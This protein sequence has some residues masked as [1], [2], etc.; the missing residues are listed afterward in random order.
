MNLTGIF[1]VDAV[2]SGSRIA[3]P[4]KQVR[5]FWLYAVLTVIDL[6]AIVSGFLVAGIFREFTPLG[7]GGWL[8]AA[9]IAPVYLGVAINSDAYGYQALVNWRRGL[10]ASLPALAFASGLVLFIAFFTRTSIEFSRV[11]Y[12]AG[13]FASGVAL[14]G[15][16]YVFQRWVRR[17]L[18][19]NLRSELV[20]V[21]RCAITPI[22]GVRVLDA[23]TCGL[24]PDP[25]DPMMLDRLGNA[26]RGADYVL[27]CCRLEDRAAWA[28]LLKGTDVP[29]YVLAPEYDMVGATALG[30]FHGHCVMQVASGPLDLRSRG[31][32][33]LMDLLIVVPAIVFMTP[34]L[35]I[36]AL[37][38]K[39]DSPGPVFFRQQ[40]LGRNNRLFD[41][42]KFR[43]MRADESD[44]S[45]ARSASRDDDRIT[46]VGRFIRA[47]SID[48]L[49]QFINVL[50]GDM[51]V[52]GPR[53]HALGSLA[54]I[55]RFWDVDQRY[56]HRHALKPGITGLAQIRGFRGAT[57]ERDDLV[58]RLQADLEYLSEWSIWKDVTI[59][60]ATLRVVVHRNAF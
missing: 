46:R 44:A 18:G 16:R 1:A 60:F 2:A 39:L 33:R 56:W 40:R 35:L 34:L 52:I 8:F 31:L 38:V 45:G 51:S 27:V 36:V 41:M 49:P 13:T 32:K 55:E 57:L 47:T 7:S 29:S 30:R 15:G 48:E 43:S 53:P 6:F 59:L 9:L 25:R 17:V 5:R 24:V 12:G 3:A 23:A 28:L 14:F 26:V 19:D 4:G 37:A 54:G 22:P 10:A 58:K 21:D 42:Y 11:V 50:H 20:I